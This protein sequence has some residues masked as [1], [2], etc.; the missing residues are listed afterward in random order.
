MIIKPYTPYIRIYIDRINVLYAPY[1]RRVVKTVYCLHSLY[2]FHI[3]VVR[4]IQT[5]IQCIYVNGF[6]GSYTVFTTLYNLRLRRIWV[7][8]FATL[9]TGHTS[10]ISWTSTT[11]SSLRVEPV[12][13]QKGCIWIRYWIRSRQHCF[14]INGTPFPIKRSHDMNIYQLWWGFCNIKRNVL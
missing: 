1:I 5:Y 14:T 12:R 4:S 9:L 11:L 7:L 6:W 3:Q 2:G 8:Y 10:H 13:G